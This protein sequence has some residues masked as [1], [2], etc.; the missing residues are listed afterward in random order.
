MPQRFC[1]R[2]TADDDHRRPG[3]LGLRD[4]ADAVG[5]AR[6]GGED[7]EAGDAGELAG[8]LGGERG[9]LLVAHVEE[10]HLR[11][12]PLLLRLHRAVVHR[13]DVRARQGEHRLDAV[14]AG[15]VDGQLAAVAGDLASLAHGAAG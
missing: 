14:G 10:P 15:D 1:G 7:G 9:G 12:V 6:A 8:R 5:D 2:A 11:P 13:E 3:E 4:R